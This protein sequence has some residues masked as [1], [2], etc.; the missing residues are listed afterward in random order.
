MENLPTHVMQVWRPGLLP[1]LKK[2]VMKESCTES[3]YRRVI[4][5][6]LE[7][8]LEKRRPPGRLFYFLYSSTALVPNKNFRELKQRIKKIK[9]VFIKEQ[10]G[11]Y[12]C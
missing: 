2:A 8:I 1:L 3:I 7:L 12:F 5:F 6:S 11:F 10:V 9:L 4:S